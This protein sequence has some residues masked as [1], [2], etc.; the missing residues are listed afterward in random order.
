MDQF[1]REFFSHHNISLNIVIDASNMSTSKFR[2]ICA[3]ENK[4]YGYNTN[5]CNEGHRIKTKHG[6]CPVCRPVDIGFINNN[7]K[8]A[9]TY[10][11]VSKAKKIIKIGITSDIEPRKD[12]LND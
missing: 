8:D 12:F 3:N 10:I 5:L 11:A 4:Y 7:K 1:T 9:Y 2:E 6:K